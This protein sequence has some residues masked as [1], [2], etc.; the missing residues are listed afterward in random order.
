LQLQALLELLSQKP[1]I[2]RGNA[3]EIMALAGATGVSKGVDSI[4]DSWDALEAGKQLAKR[5]GTVVAI[6]GKEDLV[7]S[8]E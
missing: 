1:T 3:S 6:S 8:F 7:R 2:L 4:A 5:Y